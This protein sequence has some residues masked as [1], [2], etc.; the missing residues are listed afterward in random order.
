[1]HLDEWGAGSEKRPLVTAEDVR[2]IRAGQQLSAAQ[3]RA[4]RDSPV[5]KSA[6]GERTGPK[7]KP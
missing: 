6:L 3:V 5:L 2:A 7:M 4:N 1:M